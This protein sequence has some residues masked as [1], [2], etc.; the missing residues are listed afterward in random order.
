MNDPSAHCRVRET[1]HLPLTHEVVRFT[2]PTSAPDPLYAGR[3][4]R[5]IDLWLRSTNR[6]LATR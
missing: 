3:T 1:H 6:R 4:A 2:R 5:G